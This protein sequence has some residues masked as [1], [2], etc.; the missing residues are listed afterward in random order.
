MWTIVKEIP[1]RDVSARAVPLQYRRGCLWSTF[2]FHHIHGNC[3]MFNPNSRFLKALRW[4]IPAAS[5]AAFVALCTHK[6]LYPRYLDLYSIEYLLLLI[7]TG[8]TIAYLWSISLNAKAFA[9]ISTNLGT[10]RISLLALAALGVLSIPLVR[11]AP[12][13][14]FAAV[15][16]PLL[17]V[18]VLMLVKSQRPVGSLLYLIFITVVP[19]TSAEIVLATVPVSVWA[20]SHMT[21]GMAGAL[22]FADRGLI[23]FQADMSQYDPDLAYRLRPGKHVFTTQEFSNEYAANSLGVR[24]DEE[25][26]V[27]PEVVVVGDSYSLGWGV[28]QDKT[29]SQVLERESGLK[30][31][32]TSISSYA[33]PREMRML[34]RVDRS[35]MKFLI[36][37][38]CDNDAVE[39]DT[40]AKNGNKL[41]IISE[42]NFND[43]V[44]LNLQD[45]AYHPFKYVGLL[46]EKLFQSLNDVVYAPRVPGSRSHLVITEHDA[47]A[48]FL[49]ALAHGGVDL[50][51]VQIIAFELDSVFPPQNHFADWV[52]QLK[53]GPEY[54]NFI[55]SMIAL[56]M[57]SKLRESDFFLLDD[58]INASG[59]AII[60]QELLK[61]MQHA[62]GIP[63]H[64]Q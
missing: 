10:M 5:T 25:S 61:T 1:R 3:R 38:Y 14:I 46:P 4:I 29:F 7:T 27:A 44:R 54:P 32:N 8:I 6:S 16:I 52:E 13:T 36:V 64:P 11:F 62:P 28:D 19:V 45:T 31:L 49:N 53:N 47:T 51:G 35:A 2:N 59:H 50:S 17:A 18:L 21:L 34:K 30:V 60:A 26:L 48:N 42:K 23:Q 58:H 55:H 20:R 40:F 37:Q 33:T 24:D 63:V 15:P 56:N 9:C 41:S 39:N 22:Y 12:T 57:Y 43:S